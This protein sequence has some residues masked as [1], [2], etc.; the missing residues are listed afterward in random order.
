MGIQKET[1]RETEGRDQLDE[2]IGKP[3][4][5]DIVKVNYVL[6]RLKNNKRDGKVI[7]TK[8]HKL[9]RFKITDSNSE[10]DGIYRGLNEAVKG[11]NLGEE[12]NVTLTP[13]I[14]YGEQGLSR[15]YN[16]DSGF[17]KS[18]VEIIGVAMPDDPKAPQNHKG[19]HP[20]SI[21]YIGVPSGASVELQSL[22]LMQINN[23]A[24]KIP[25]QSCLSCICNAILVGLGC[26]GF[27]NN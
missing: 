4:V 1:I 23:H 2:V 6:Y 21:A 22:S 3:K 17:L 8:A 10:Q 13:D 26:G 7:D 15:Y 14:A 9:V 12:A 27:Q 16:A 19:R 25:E 11:M 20:I 5:G 24:R 18:G